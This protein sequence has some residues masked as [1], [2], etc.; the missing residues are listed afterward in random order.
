MTQ[1]MTTLKEK[2]ARLPAP[3]RAKV[4]VRA[5][6]LIAEGTSL[7]E[8]RLAHNKTRAKIAK[9]LNIGHWRAGYELWTALKAQYYRTA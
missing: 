3:R 9:K 2:M 5:T 8:L 4:E 1:D 6:Q 7:Q